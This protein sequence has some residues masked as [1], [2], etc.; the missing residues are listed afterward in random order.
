MI[1]TKTPMRISLGGGGTDLPFYCSKKACSLF[2][3]TINKSVFVSAKEMFENNIKLSYSKI[4]I[5][6]DV[7]KIKNNRAREALNLCNVSRGVEIVTMADEIVTKDK[8]PYSYGR[9]PNCS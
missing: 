9:V 8:V 2:T 7:D 3:A 1:I 4:E 5:T 6:N